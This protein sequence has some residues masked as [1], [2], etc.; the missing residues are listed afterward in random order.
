MCSYSSL[1]LVCELP[2]NASSLQHL[3]NTVSSEAFSEGRNTAGTLRYLSYLYILFQFIFVSFF[4][5]KF[6][7]HTLPEKAFV[8]VPVE[9]YG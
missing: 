1:A 8:L 9:T 4:F 7:Y 5:F 2:E 6:S 3:T